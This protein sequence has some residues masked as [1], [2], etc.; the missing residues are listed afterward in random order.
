MT[1]PLVPNPLNNCTFSIQPKS[2][3]R[4]NHRESFWET[5]TKKVLQRLTKQENYNFSQTN[6][7]PGMASIEITK[8]MSGGGFFPLNHNSFS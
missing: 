8:Q 3:Q 5:L 6:L 7:T 2:D 1:M 4:F